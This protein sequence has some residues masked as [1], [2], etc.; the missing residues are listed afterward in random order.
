M[1]DVFISYSSKDRG[2]ARTLAAA[3]IQR[4]HSV[5][6]DR[7]IVTGE[8][9]DH[10]IERELESA[11]TVVVLWSSEAVSS[12]WVKNEAASAAERNVL[13]PA[14]LDGARLPLEFR[15]RQTADLR[16]WE[17]DPSHEGFHSLC[18][19]IDSLL[20]RDASRPQQTTQEASPARKRGRYLMI[21]AIVALIVGGGAFLFFG[22]PGDASL[23]SRASDLSAAMG[24]TSNLAAKVAGIYEGRVVSDSKGASRSNVVVTITELGPTSVR[25]TSPYARIGSF[26]IEL[27]LNGSQ[28]LNAG[29]DTPFI[30]NLDAKP[31]TLSL[32]PRNEL[33]YQGV[34]IPGAET[35]Q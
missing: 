34:R 32:S 33:A 28:V 1:A 2:S 30:V 15:R 17:G 7:E 3:L 22:G 23:Q 4:G 29:G 24:S 8:S 26:D 11:R 9:F 10:V 31:A 5:W 14:N 18:R 6:W 20:G 27:D 21:A 25:V 13:L 35:I 12:E 19:G 16:G